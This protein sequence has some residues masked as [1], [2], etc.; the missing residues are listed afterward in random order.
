MREGIT[1][2]KRI[3]MTGSAL[4][5]LALVAMWAVMMY[6]TAGSPRWWMVLAAILISV[7]GMLTA[8]MLYHLTR[9]GAVLDSPAFTRSSRALTW[10][11]LL[12][13]LVPVY[14][15]RIVALFR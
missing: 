15:P 1:M 2:H 5:A 14:G 12:L 3:A 13:I 6:L 8:Y 11:A 9:T 10:A 7:N 4:L